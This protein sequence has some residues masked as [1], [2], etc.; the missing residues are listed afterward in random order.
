[1]SAT[2]RIAQGASFSEVAK[3]LGKSEKD[4]DLGTVTKAGMIDRTIA[5]AAFALKEGEVS[6]PIQGRFGPALVRV[7]KIEPEQV[8]PFQ[9]VAGELK[10]EL[11]TARAKADVLKI[12]DKIEDARAEGKTLT[13]AAESLKLPAR[14][15]SAID[16]SGRDPS[17]V[18]I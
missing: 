1:E 7:L 6:A 3:E 2:Q 4:I 5:D 13:E 18:P 15:I 11:A 10:Q 8:R 16:R 17:G 14:T 12:Y 9:E